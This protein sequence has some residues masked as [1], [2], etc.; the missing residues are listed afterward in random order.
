MA[1][2]AGPGPGQDAASERRRPY[3]SPVRRERARETRDRI[4]ASGC[5]LARE[6]PTW[7]WT[8]LTAAAVADRAGVNKTTV[9]RHF[10]TERDLHD[11]VMRRLEDEA[12][13]SI[14]ALD[15]ANFRATV[16]RSLANLAAFA[17]RAEGQEPGTPTLDADRR[18][19]DALLRVV[20]PV[21]ADRSEDQRHMVAAVLDVLW[22][23]PSHRRL[24]EVWGFDADQA[25][26]AILWALDA[27]L[28][29]AEADPPPRPP[30]A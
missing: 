11:A 19:R 4:V 23:T 26:S 15:L 10:G 28:W 8:G 12:G 24:T 2:Q 7:D 6:F 17:A 29:A 5:A 20:L 30:R 14:D 9:Y 13:I 21:T 25:T 3:D 1:E 18:R 27:V 16:T 22:G